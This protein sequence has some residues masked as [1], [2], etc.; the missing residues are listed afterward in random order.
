MAIISHVSLRLYVDY[1][2]SVAPLGFLWRS[3]FYDFA[4]LRASPA[5][6]IDLRRFS[7]GSFIPLLSARPFTLSRGMMMMS[8]LCVACSLFTAFALS[9]QDR[10]AATRPHP[11]WIGDGHEGQTGRMDG[12]GPKKAALKK[13]AL[14]PARWG[15]YLIRTLALVRDAV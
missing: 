15:H 9:N 3:L 5:C 13:A 14:L 7:S 6:W 2:F 11:K 8:A 1:I 10:D 12:G 4:M